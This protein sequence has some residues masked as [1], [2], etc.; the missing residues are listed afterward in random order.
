MAYLLALDQGTT[1][2]RA[3]VFDANY[4]IIALAQQ[5][6]PQIYPQPGWVEQDPERI[7]LSQLETARH[8]LAKAGVTAHDVAALGIANQ[9]ETT[10][11]WDRRT[12]E[13]VCNAIVWQDR[14]TA[15]LC[16]AI[17]AD[18]YEAE[19]RER[20]GLVL[21]PYFSGTKLQWMLDNIVGAR[22]RAERGE[23]AFGTV[24]TWLIWRLTHGRV[25]AT[26][27][28]NAS[29]TLL[30]NIH[31][32]RWDPE[33]LALMRIPHTLL[34]TVHR[35]AAAYGQSEA[36]VFGAPIFIGAA[37]GDQQAALAG[38]GCD[39][40]GMIKNTY[41]TGCFMLMHTGARPKLSDQGLL[42][43][44]A[45]QTDARPSYALEGSVFVAGAAV[46]WLRDGLGIV[47][48]AADI[49][50]LAR[51]VPD[52]GGVYFVPALVGLGSP[53]W[54][55][56]AR[57]G[58]LGLSRGATRAHLARATLEAIAFQSAELVEVMQGTT[59][60][61]I[62]S[63]RVD[64]GAS[65]NDLLMQIQ[66]DLLGVPVIR[67]HIA[68]TTALGAAYLAGLSAG[69]QAPDP[70]VI[71]AAHTANER[72]FLP[73]IEPSEAAA[74]LRQWKRAVARCRNWEVRDV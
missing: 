32:C 58:I 6:L 53:Y 71:S 19:V 24:D 62:T 40:S 65:T 16:E 34:P 15:P 59:G 54:D 39:R 41:G 20:T 67:P 1:S 12:G 48:S 47:G 43:T 9:R 13:P 45:A 26:D 68:E 38:H 57:G 18:G 29:R 27:V 23:L 28:T 44:C 42:T 4:R 33:L 52:C 21:D 3:I 60:E 14:R 36:S 50:N 7:W 31:E 64:G 2:S 49:E 11:L 73:S 22:E 8:T 72:V 46:Q 37:A 61:T 74:R 35:S 55:P 70:E 66:A 51:S 69:M 30:F 5:E 17:R 63:L 25:H 56:T 10:L